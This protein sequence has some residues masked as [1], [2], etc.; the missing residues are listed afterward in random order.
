MS[1]IYYPGYKPS[2]DYHTVNE[3]PYLGYNYTDEARLENGAPPRS[4][5]AH[6]KDP[7][8]RFNVVDSVVKHRPDL[9]INHIKLTRRPSPS[10]EVDDPNGY[11]RKRYS[12]GQFN[13]YATAY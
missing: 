2:G 1:R 11:V 12:S 5:T 8:S 4:F 9:A 13:R 6:D 10:L 7:I 3:I